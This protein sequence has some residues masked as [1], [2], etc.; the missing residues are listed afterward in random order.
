MTKRGILKTS[1]FEKALLPPWMVVGA[2]RGA[3]IG[4]G[5]ELE[6]LAGRAVLGMRDSGSTE[7]ADLRDRA[8]RDV[9]ASGNKLLP[10]F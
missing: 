7:K 8:L 6:G 5:T 9:G 10:P 2:S 1:G 3:A 4:L